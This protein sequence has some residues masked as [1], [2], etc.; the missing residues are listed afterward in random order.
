MAAN[1]QVEAMLSMVE[2]KPVL[3]GRFTNIRRIGTDGGQG[4]FS[5]VFTADDSVTGRKVALKFFR[6]D[7]RQD[8]YRL[9]CFQREAEILSGLPQCRD[10]IS[11]VSPISQFDEMA[12]TA[13]GFSIAIPFAFYGLELAETDV[14][15][16]LA[17]GKIS[18]IDRLRIFHCMC[19]A[20]QRLHIEGVTNRDIKSSNFLKMHD[21]TIKMS[22]FGTARRL[23]PFEAPIGTVYLAPVGDVRYVAPE[24]QI[25][26]HD[27]YPEVSFG[28]DMFALGATLLELMTGA[29]LGPLI[30]SADLLDALDRCVSQ[31]TWNERRLKFDSTITD[32]ANSNP[33]PRMEA[34]ATGI[35]HDVRP[36][37]QGL[38]E[39]LCHLDYRRRLADFGQIFL[40]VNRC[41][42]VLEHT[43]KYQAWIRER[44][45]RRAITIQKMLKPQAQP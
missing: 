9:A 42:F 30:Y 19:R 14:D 32:I 25:G 11:L 37:L 23:R 31:P 43:Q 45:R 26:L 18:I 41:I 44:Q 20:T 34:I 21:G 28:G 15:T 5:F 39:S 8:A 36:I 6:P 33:L 22:D 4:H 24:L 2:A 27:Q 29:A 10:F 17:N 16:H 3:D 7:R 35:P 40:R 1:P 38:F 12:T 13:T